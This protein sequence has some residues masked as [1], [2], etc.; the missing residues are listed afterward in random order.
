MTPDRPIESPGSAGA[1]S[2]A[3]RCGGSID[4]R[5]PHPKLRARLPVLW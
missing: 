1:R 2:N 5:A 4:E 3:K